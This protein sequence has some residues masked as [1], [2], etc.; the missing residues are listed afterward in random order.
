[1]AGLEPRG[2]AAAGPRTRKRA[3]VLV[4]DGCRPEEIDSGLTPN[5]LAL[6]EGGLHHPRATSMPVMETIPNH[7]MMMTGVR[8]DRSGVPANAVYDR[9]LGEI[10]TLDQPS[11]L[12]FP[13]VIERL[14]KRGLRTGTVLSKEY[15]YGIFGERATHRWEPAPIIPISGHAPDE[16][17][18][19]ATLDMLEEVDPHLIFVNLGDV[20]RLGHTDLTGPTTLEVAR[21]A[22]LIQHRPARGATSWTS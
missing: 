14:N 4:V 22:A 20:D 19:R 1:M 7:T 11:D 3:Y 2:A 21:R 15:L 13:T 9:A 17:T 18:M 10:R 8:P 5:L 6:R 16:F 12:R